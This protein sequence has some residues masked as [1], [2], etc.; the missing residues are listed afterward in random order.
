[1]WQQLWFCRFPIPLSSELPS[2]VSAEHCRETQSWD[3]LPS[4]EDDRS[5]QPH[6]GTAESVLWPQHSWRGARGG[7]PAIPEQWF[8]WHSSGSQQKCFLGL[9]QGQGGESWARLQ[10]WHITYVM[11][12][13]ILLLRAHPSQKDPREHL[14]G[15]VFRISQFCALENRE[16][17]SE[18]PSAFWAE[19]GAHCGTAWHEQIPLRPCFPGGV[20]PCAGNV[21]T[22]KTW[23]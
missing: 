1:M 15:S 2:G 10:S 16:F 12:C 23:S 18:S 6:Q 11:L 21:E 8:E 4:A 13:F 7:L 14:L 17:G 22:W 20:S 3:S 9:T 19:H 5:W